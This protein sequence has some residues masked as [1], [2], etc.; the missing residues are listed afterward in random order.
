[1]SSGKIK[2]L[3]SRFRVDSIRARLTLLF[4]AILTVTLLVF[5]SILYQVF[6]RNHEREFDVALYNHAVD[7]SSSINVDFYGDF[8]FNAGNLLN[9]EKIFPFALGRSFMQVVS[10]NG[11]IIARTNNLKH[12]HLPIYSED[13]QAVFQNGSAFRTLTKEEM[14]D[15]PSSQRTQYRL[16]TY[17]ARKSEPAFILQVAVPMALLYQ[18]TY[19]L[20]I[21]FLVAIPLT[22]LGA[23]FGGFYLSGKALQPVRDII[24]KAE[25]LNPAILSERLP[26]GPVEDEIQ[27]LTITLNKLLE[28]IQKAFDSHESFI[29]DASHQ[30]KTPIAVLRGELDVFKSKPRSPGEIDAFLKSSS[31]EL[32]H[33]SRLLDDL[34]ILAQMDAG[35]ASF[36]I[37]PLRLDEVVLEAVSRVELLA[38]QKNIGIRFDIDQTN[39]LDDFQMEGDAD[40]LQSMVRNLLDNAIKYSPAGSPVEVKLF[41]RGY[42]LC[43]EVKDY[44]DPIP[45]DKAST[46]FERFQ[47][48]AQAK[49]GPGGFGLGLTIARRIAEAHRGKISILQDN[50]PGKS[51]LVEMKKV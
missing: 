49:N 17:F 19:S 33:L 10:P 27:K 9:N 43:V 29:S 22:I 14:A 50:P 41:E 31:Q 47:R 21:F 48:G 8:V 15:I 28:R 45:A 18:E 3:L 36:S 20:L 11:V 40:L 26:V 35:S 24:L 51:F 2:K 6:V 39:D 46:I 32:T 25:R 13:W 38:T 12:L 7:V 30:L 1:M 37:R 23:M 42:S 4:V 44:G 34:L 5:C 16:I